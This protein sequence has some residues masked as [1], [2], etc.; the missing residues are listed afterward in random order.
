MVTDSFDDKK[1]PST[2]AAYLYGHVQ[3]YIRKP[4]S[5]VPLLQQELA[6]L[7]KI[8]CSLNIYHILYKELQLIKGF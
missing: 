8:V 5:D 6:G 1:L 4:Q 7:I 3:I 2:V